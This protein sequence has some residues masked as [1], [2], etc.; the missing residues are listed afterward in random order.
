M[1]FGKRFFLQ[2]TLNCKENYLL[3]DLYKNDKEKSLESGRSNKWYF[4][5]CRGKNNDSDDN[6]EDLV[7][8]DI[9]MDLHI[10]VC[11]YGQ[12]YYRA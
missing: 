8:E 12:E 5:F 2:I 10:V 11:R 7:R 1:H 9:D 3:L 6:L 4:E